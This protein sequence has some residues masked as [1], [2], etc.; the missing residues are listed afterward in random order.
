MVEKIEVCQS[1]SMAAQAQNTCTFKNWTKSLF[2]PFD[3]V[4]PEYL[5]TIPDVSA[6]SFSTTGQGLP[7]PPESP[8]NPGRSLIHSLPVRRGESAPPRPFLQKNKQSLQK[9]L[10]V[11][12]RRLTRK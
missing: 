1:K 11:M 12:L 8:D 3:D 2:E 7:N 9:I 4:D 10:P 5:K 6:L